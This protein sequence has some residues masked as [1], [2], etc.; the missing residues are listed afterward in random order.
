[1]PRE[2]KLIILFQLNERRKGDHFSTKHKKRFFTKGGAAEEESTIKHEIFYMILDSVI[3]GLSTRYDAAYKMD[4]MFGFLGRYLDLTEQQM[5]TAC[6]T[7][8]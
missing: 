8:A 2:C 7:L 6:V 1:M 4:K 5:S 3:A